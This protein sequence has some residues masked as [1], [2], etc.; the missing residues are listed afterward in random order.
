MP[1]DSLWDQNFIL[2]CYSG[3]NDYSLRE[4]LEHLTVKEEDGALFQGKIKAQTSIQ[5]Q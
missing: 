3:C 1:F 4:F 5:L 2:L